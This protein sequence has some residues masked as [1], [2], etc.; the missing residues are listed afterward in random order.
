MTPSAE[1]PVDRQVISRDLETSRR[2]LHGLLTPADTADL[3]R[4][5]EGTRWTN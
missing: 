2:Q 1:S 4:R 3:R 5:S